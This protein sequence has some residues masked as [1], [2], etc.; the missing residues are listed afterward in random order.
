MLLVWLITFPLWAG[1]SQDSQRLLPGR[2]H[3]GKKKHGTVDT[4]TEISVT[5]WFF[6]MTED[7]WEGFAYTD[8]GLW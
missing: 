1:K 5:N 4:S 3:W 8:P 2:P 6:I 7:Q